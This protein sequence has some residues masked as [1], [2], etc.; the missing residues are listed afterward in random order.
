MNENI[1]T[2]DKCG[3]YNKLIL[4]SKDKEQQNIFNFSKNIKT[5]TLKV[6]FFMCNGCKTRYLWSIVNNKISENIY[7]MNILRIHIKMKAKGFAQGKTTNDS[8]NATVKTN[9][10]KIEKLI[11]LNISESKRLKVK[12]ENL[13]HDYEM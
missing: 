2:C 5:E 6:T 1:I 12:Y 13:M 7:K 3:Q 4:V 11:N 9:N 10:K 8:Y